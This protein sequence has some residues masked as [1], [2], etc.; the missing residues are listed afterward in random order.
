[1]PDLRG[2]IELAMR[3]GYPEP[4]LRLS[5]DVRRRWLESYVDQLLTRDAELI[6]ARR[7]PDRLRRYFEAIALNTAGVVDERTLYDAASIDR[8]T[9]SAYERLLRN[10][11]VL[12]AVPAWSSDRLKR[13]V[14]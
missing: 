11:L 10:L 1:P 9:A 8:K 12:D 13:L 6:D 14:R 3:G 7:D 5:D 2:Y 4:A